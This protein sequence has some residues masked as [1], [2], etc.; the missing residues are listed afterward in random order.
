MNFKVCFLKK[1]SI[2][3]L[4]VKN[5]Q[6]KTTSILGGIFFFHVKIEQVR[7]TKNYTEFEG[8]V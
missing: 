5:K 1:K 4:T 6:T 2:W 7:G 3:P 8:Q